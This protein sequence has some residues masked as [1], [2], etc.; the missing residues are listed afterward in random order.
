ML[1]D[2]KSVLFTKHEWDSNAFQAAV[3]SLETGERKVL[4]EGA[5]GAQYYPTGH[6]IYTIENDIFAAPFDPDKLEITGG[7]VPLL[8]DVFT[9]ARRHY[10]ISDSGTLLYIQGETEATGTS[11]AQRTLVWVDRNGNE[12]TVPTQPNAYGMPR[13]SP[14]GTRVALNANTGDNQDIWVWDFVRKTMTR[15][16][17][18]D[19]DDDCPLWT[20]DGKRIVFRSSRKEGIYWKAADGTGEVEH[21]YSVPRKFFFPWSWSNDGKTMALW[22]INMGTTTAGIGFD[23]GAISME[24][25]KEFRPLLEEKY[26]ET[27][28]RISPDGRWMAY[29]SDESDQAEIYARPFPEV[30]SGGRW[31]VSTNGGRGPLWSPNGKELFYQSDEGIMVVDV[32]T[33]PT[34]RPGNPKILFRGTYFSGSLL[35]APITNWDIHPD[36]ERFLMIKQSQTTDEESATGIPHKIIVVTN[37]FEELKERVPVD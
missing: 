17:F 3:E 15:L 22:V 23:I 31:Q 4:I 7:Q 19:A 1:P 20:P 32:E 33:E 11:V 35:Q 5:V 14:D 8:E 25:D 37:W 34:F 12:E 24:G 29:T 2:G 9:F 6:L 26:V 10:D 36:G 30:E 28:P 21:L 18:D 16:T 27:L 13:I